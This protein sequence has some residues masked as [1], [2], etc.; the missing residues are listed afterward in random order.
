MRKG[1]FQIIKAASAAVLASLL[2]V[3]AF[4]LIIQLFSLP[5]DAV[6]PVNQA[7]KILSVAIGGLIFIRGDKGWLKGGIYG[8]VAVMATYFLYGGISRS[9]SIEWTF[10]VEILLGVVCGVISGIIAVNVKKNV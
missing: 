5:L 7:F 6:K 4:T 3:L 10:A 1:I 2:F 8:F 9:L